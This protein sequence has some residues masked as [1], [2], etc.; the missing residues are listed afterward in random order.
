VSPDRRRVDL[1]G[2][3]PAV[4]LAALL[5]L[6]AL[7]FDAEPLWV[8]VVVLPLLALGA[9]G[10]VLLAARGLDVARTVE[11]RRIVEDEPLVVH[12]DVRARR[13][14]LPGGWLHDPLLGAPAPLRAGRRAARVRI[15]VRFA[16]RG[17]R[18][19]GVPA[20]TVADPL[21]LAS[22]A[23][24]A[25][26][27][28]DELLV[29]PRTGPVTAAAGGGRAGRAAR[30]RRATP[31]VE[32]DVDGLR[33]LR[34]GTSAS[35][36]FWPSL[37]RGAEPMERRLAADADTTP[38]VVLDPRAPARDE[39]LDAAVRAS[40]SLALHLARA[41]GCAVLLPGDRRATA[42]DATLAG[43]AHLHARLATVEAVGR[44]ALAEL[45]TR[46]GVVVLVSARVVARPP[47][48]LLHA[49]AQGRVL[50]VP[51]ELAGRRPAFAVAGCHG[52]ELVNP[53][54][55]SRAAAGILAEAPG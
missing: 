51:G 38:L 8:P 6:C 10:W 34:S 23:V 16:R 15:E 18:A 54:R 3:A 13:V 36:V 28:E 2:A 47:D 55:A 31:A 11:A 45:A 19:L 37:A 39:D 41:G 26:G 4:G 53:G 21:G 43:W 46:R 35:R 29:L 20:V 12:L 52:Y 7:L 32:V 27:A 22:R 14:P 24:A 17:R 40:A 1:R 44:P 49:P 5:G 42:L 9:A 50:V 33:P 30:G 25:G 48:A